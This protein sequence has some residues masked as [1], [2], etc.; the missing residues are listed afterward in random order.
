MGA[1]TKGGADSEAE[2]GAEARLR[3]G[4]KTR[5]KARPKGVAAM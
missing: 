5:L 1:W 3:W 2:I 4:L